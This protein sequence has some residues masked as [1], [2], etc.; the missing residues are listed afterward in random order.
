MSWAMTKTAISFNP[1][2]LPELT[3]LTFNSFA[4]RGNYIRPHSMAAVG[5]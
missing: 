5:D 4:A 1:L 2:G 3:E